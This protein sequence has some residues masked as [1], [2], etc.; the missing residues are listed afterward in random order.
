MVAGLAAGISSSSLWTDSYISECSSS[1]RI[2]FLVF[3]S[4]ASSTKFF[5]GSKIN[6]AN[7]RQK[8]PWDVPV[9]AQVAAILQHTECCEDVL[10]GCHGI[11]SCSFNFLYIG[12]SIGLCRPLVWL[13]MVLHPLPSHQETFQV[14]IDGSDPRHSSFFSLLVFKNGFS[15]MDECGKDIKRVI[16]YEHS[17]TGHY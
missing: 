2:Q 12:L 5:T 1:F 6:Q 10:E 4:S 3:H 14:G 13:I 17:K 7:P 9:K 11:F 16:F 8:N 15:K